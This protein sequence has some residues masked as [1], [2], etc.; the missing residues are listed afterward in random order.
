MDWT[1]LLY[2]AV[3]CSSCVGFTSFFIALRQVIGS[4]VSTLARWSMRYLIAVA[5][6]CTLTALMPPLLS[7]VVSA[8]AA[9]QI[10]SGVACVLMTRLDVIFIYRLPRIY[11]TP[12]SVYFWLL[13]VAAVL[14]DMGFAACAF[15]FARGHESF[16]FSSL[17]TVELAVIYGYFSAA[18]MELLPFEWE[19]ET[20]TIGQAEVFEI[21]SN[22]Q[23]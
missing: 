20:A 22:E 1:Y 8:K 17:E 3:L 18:L 4:A 7:T 2:I 12:R 19:L 13:Y 10:A 15:G 14:A 21:R 5:L 16:V 9:I 11:R 23:G 6:C